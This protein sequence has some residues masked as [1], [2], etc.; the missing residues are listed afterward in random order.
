VEAAL[1]IPVILVL[2]LGFIQFSSMYFTRG[3]MVQAAREGAR[4]LAVQDGTPDDAAIRTEQ[5]LQALLG[6]E[7]V[8]SYTVTAGEITLGDGTTVAG[9]YV[10]VPAEEASIIGDPFGFMGVKTL[11]A[12]AVMRP[13]GR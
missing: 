7:D 1:V 2:L 8:D 13:E 3:T 4:A 11:K 6:V 9:V 5:V 12:A 10:S